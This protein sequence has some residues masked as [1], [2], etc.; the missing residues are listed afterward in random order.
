MKKYFLFFIIFLF[1]IFSNE[2]I[3]AASKYSMEEEFFAMQEQVVVSASKRAQ[4]ISD[5][6][7]SIGVVTRDEI[8]NLGAQSLPEALRM[9]AGVYVQ[10]INGGQYE[11]AIRGTANMP[12]SNGP[13]SALSRSILVLID[14]RSFFNDC[15]GGTA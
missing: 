1:F 8:E 15:F 3:F 7:V 10:Q 6:P 11:V 5:A 2:L 13:F 12:P 4:K 14:G 9:V